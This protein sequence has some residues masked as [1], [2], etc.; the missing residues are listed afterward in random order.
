MC[1]FL[2]G[3]AAVLPRASFAADPA[4]EAAAQP[5]TGHRGAAK[6][7][8]DY[9]KSKYKAYKVLTEDENHSYR[10]DAK[11]NA[12]P[13]ARAKSRPSKRR[14]RPRPPLSEEDAASAPK[15]KARPAPGN[16]GPPVARTP[17]PRPT[18]APATAAPEPAEPAR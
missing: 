1:L 4:P 11:G 8:Y 13:P 16:D 10:F 2:A 14:V 5:R 15:R 18:L 12:I 9:D 7:G 6:R 17:V 3:A